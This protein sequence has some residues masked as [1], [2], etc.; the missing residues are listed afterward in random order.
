MKKRYINIY[1]D[2][3]GRF[4]SNEDLFQMKIGKRE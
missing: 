1:K 2:D 4:I 3:R